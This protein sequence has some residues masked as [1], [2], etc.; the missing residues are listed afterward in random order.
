MTQTTTTTTTTAEMLRGLA[1]GTAAGVRGALGNLISA[2]AVERRVDLLNEQIDAI[3]CAVPITPAGRAAYQTITAHDYEFDSDDDGEDAAEFARENLADAIAACCDY[4]TSYR[5]YRRAGFPADDAADAANDDSGAA[6]ALA[7]AHD[8]ILLLAACLENPAG[9]PDDDVRLTPW[10][11]PQIDREDGDTF[12]LPDSSIQVAEW[13]AA[14][15]ELMT[16]N[17]GCEHGCGAGNMFSYHA[18][19][20]PGQ[21]PADVRCTMCG[22]SNADLFDGADSAPFFCAGCGRTNV[23]E[24]AGRYLVQENILQQQQGGGNGG[25]DDNDPDA[26][27]KARAERAALDAEAAAAAVGEGWQWGDVIKRAA[28]AARRSS[29][30]AHAPRRWT[31]YGN[32][33]A[34]TGLHLPSVAI[35]AQDAERHARTADNFLRQSAAELGMVEHQQQA[36]QQ[37][38]SAPALERGGR[39]AGVTMTCDTC[40]EIAD[41]VQADDTDGVRRAICGSCLARQ[42]SE[43]AVVNFGQTFIDDH[44]NRDLPTGRELKRTKTTVTLAMTLAELGE[45]ESDADYYA[46]QKQHLNSPELC[47][48]AARVLRKLHQLVGIDWEAAGKAAEEAELAAWA[49]DRSGALRQTQQLQ[50]Q[51]QRPQTAPPNEAPAMVRCCDC[52]AAFVE[53]DANTAVHLC[54]G[55]RA[56]HRSQHQAAA[57]PQE[58]VLD[59][60]TV[61]LRDR[62]APVT[63]CGRSS[64][65]VQRTWNAAIV[66]CAECADA[67]PEEV[68]GLYALLDELVSYH[69]IASRL[70]AGQSAT[71]A[72]GAA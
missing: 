51:A 24:S 65:S 34:E 19:G 52:R 46:S 37:Q 42:R 62:G 44:E 15:R 48:A 11:A 3:G 41:D 30:R 58:Y 67:R 7:R 55:C 17:G 12:T 72:E 39:A 16:A 9:G 68:T 59:V 22:R 63:A 27:D 40:G 29:D 2:S 60:Y 49:A 13:R 61:H 38:S 21:P 70:A 66:T 5:E 31:I 54:D 28:E 10:G 56:L 14:S 4:E 25:R 18:D 8:S 50:Q 45:L 20:C 1:D 23:G 69:P 43:V 35:C 26:P 53:H 36:Q 71:G 33:H 57:E 47:D 6:A 64:E 32:V